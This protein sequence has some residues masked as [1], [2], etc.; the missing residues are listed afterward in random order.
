MRL[1]AISIIALTVG[2]VST[3][4]IDEYL[5]WQNVGYDGFAKS[6]DTV[7]GDG[8]KNC[9]F[10]SVMS[11]DGRKAS[12]R[13]GIECAKNAYEQ[14][15]AFKFGTV[16]L[17]IDSYAH[18]VLVHSSAGENWLIVY[19]I[20]VDGSDPQI[21]FQKC[22]SVTFPIRGVAYEGHN[23]VEYDGSNDPI[24]NDS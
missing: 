3:P 8:A 23:C 10:F 20:I 16:R 21:W 12:E 14:G 11:R 4:E 9:G 19:D 6:I 18:E 1:L 17:P 15:F 24:W 5:D 2:C 13:F 7:A 22:E